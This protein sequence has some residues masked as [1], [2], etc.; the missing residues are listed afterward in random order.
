MF[1]FTYLLS[2]PLLFL[3][4]KKLEKVNGPSFHYCM[5]ARG[6]KV[7]VLSLI[8]SEFWTFDTTIVLKYHNCSQIG[9][10]TK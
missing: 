7:Y 3:E 1:N 2:P 10:I 8:Y 5:L 6:K 4:S 9:P